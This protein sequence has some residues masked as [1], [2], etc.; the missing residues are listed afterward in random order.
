MLELLV[1]AN[2]FRAIFALRIGMMDQ[3]GEAR[4]TV[5]WIKLSPVCSQRP[6]MASRALIC[7]AALSLCASSDLNRLLFSIPRFSAI[8]FCWR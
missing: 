8:F 6:S 1:H 2:G 3:A 7:A 5:S 4:A